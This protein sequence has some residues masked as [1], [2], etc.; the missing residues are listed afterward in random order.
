MILGFLC[1]I[2]LLGDIMLN[3]DMIKL[4][5]SN[6]KKCTIYNDDYVL[7]YKTMPVTDDKLEEYVNK[8]N[9]LSKSGVNIA[10]II[11]YKLVG[12]SSKFNVGSYTKGVFLERRAHGNCIG[13][14]KNIN[15]NNIENIE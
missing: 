6:G 4:A 11:D 9:E 12:P 13:D 2:F 5:T 14:I 10:N 15:F 3:E 7:L 8:I 1:D